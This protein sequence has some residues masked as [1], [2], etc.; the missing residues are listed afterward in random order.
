MQHACLL[1]RALLVRSER[2]STPAVSMSQ[3]TMIL[4]RL[5]YKFVPG[6]TLTYCLPPL[7]PCRSNLLHIPC[8]TMSH[9]S[10]HRAHNTWKT[11]CM[12]FCQPLALFLRDRGLDGRLRTVHHAGLSKTRPCRMT[13]DVAKDVTKHV[14]HLDQ[15]CSFLANI[16]SIV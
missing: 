13:H 12:Q 6:A 1:T 3:T 4:D 7:W 14:W 2:L 9:P 8:L 16:S 11:G 10:S 5:I 15:V